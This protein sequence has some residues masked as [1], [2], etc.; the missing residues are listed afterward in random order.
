MTTKERIIRESIAATETELSEIISILD[1]SPLLGIIEVRK[2]AQK[3]LNEYD[4]GD[5]RLT[6]LIAELADEEKRLFKVAEK[7]KDSIALI[8]RRVKLDFE[9]QDL[10]NELYWTER[11]NS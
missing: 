8:D 11:N 5:P 10:N 6:K 3:L 7:Q 1:A 2:K 9:L 4:I